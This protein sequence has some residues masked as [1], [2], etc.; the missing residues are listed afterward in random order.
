V[1]L[2]ETLRAMVR[3]EVA[4]VLAERDT[5]P[6]NVFYSQHDSPLGKRRFLD[7]ARRGAF[8]SSKRGKLILAMRTDVDAWIRAGERMPKS[9]PPKPPEKPKSKVERILAEMKGAKR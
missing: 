7:A 5:K 1:T 4:R 9:E 3:E 6:E 8:P 2:D